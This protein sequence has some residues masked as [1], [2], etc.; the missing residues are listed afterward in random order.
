MDGAALVLAA[1]REIRSA[2]VAAVPA[3]RR[4]AFTLREA[5]WLGAGF[6]SVDVDGE[7][8]DEGERA[9]RALAAHLDERRGLRTPPA[10]PA[11]RWFRPTPDPFDIE[12]GHGRRGGAHRQALREVDQA[13][14]ELGRLIAGAP[15]AAR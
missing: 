14:R 1:T 15:A 6:E 7:R 12:D 3:A 4:R 9:V 11:R 8:L 5:L 2:V 10:P 13:A